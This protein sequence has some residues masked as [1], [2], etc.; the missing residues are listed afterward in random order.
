MGGASFAPTEAWFHN[1]RL[2]LYNQDDLKLLCGRASR[3]DWAFCPVAFASGLSETSHGWSVR[4]EGFVDGLA[5][6]SIWPR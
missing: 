6:L 1:F 2:F 4:L 5:A 3:R